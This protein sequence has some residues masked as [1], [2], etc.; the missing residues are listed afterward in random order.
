MAVA[1]AVAATATV[2]SSPAHA[3]EVWID[4]ATDT[5]DGAIWSFDSSGAGLIDLGNN[6]TAYFKKRWPGQNKTITLWISF[7]CNSNR[8]Q[9]GDVTDISI[10][11][12]GKNIKDAAGGVWVTYEPGTIGKKLHDIVCK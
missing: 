2:F 5:K 9:T 10:D 12:N 11:P 1:A 3:A 7:E 6:K 8:I 4:V